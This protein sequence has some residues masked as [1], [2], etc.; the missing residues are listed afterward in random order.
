MAPVGHR[1]GGIDAMD[2]MMMLMHFVGGGLGWA[3]RGN[4]RGR[5]GNRAVGLDGNGAAFS[6]R[7]AQGWGAWAGRLGISIMHH[8][9]DAMA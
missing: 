9:A 5:F 6:G 1:A 3:A 4:S 8:G 7:R 2:D